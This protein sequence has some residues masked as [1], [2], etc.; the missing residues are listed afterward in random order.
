[1]RFAPC[2]FIL[3]L[4]SFGQNVRAEFVV[5]FDGNG[6][7]AAQNWL[8]YFALGGTALQNPQASGVRL[9][10]DGP[11]SAGYGS[12]QPTAQLANIAFPTLNR[13]NGFELSF[14]LAVSSETH[15]R[16][17]RAGFSVSL[18]GSDAKGI[19]LGFW[20]SRIWAQNVGFT[21]GESFNIDTTVQ[22]DYRLRI[23]NDAYA[24]YAG[25]NPLLS[26]AVR[27]YGGAVPYTL[28]NMLFMGDNTTSASAD[29]TLGIVTLQSNLAAVPEPASLVLSLVSLSIFRLMRIRKH[30]S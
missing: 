1:M 29:I 26:G 2:F 6:L 28:P 3:L 14:S 24:L 7:P 4:V 15:S 18:L 22:R 5:L 27:T 10:T 13:S 16:N 21:Q 23:E 25:A 17:D 19:E 30:R 9:Q 20:D 8:A 11:V 12:Y